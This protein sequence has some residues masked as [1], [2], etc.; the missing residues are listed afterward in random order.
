[1]KLFEGSGEAHKH[2]EK[3]LNAQK[4]R[5]LSQQ[6]DHKIIYM[7]IKIKCNHR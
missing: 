2:V 6:T 4:Q 5:P 1:M 3:V 7:Y